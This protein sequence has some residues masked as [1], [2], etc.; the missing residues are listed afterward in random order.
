MTSPDP[1]HPVDLIIP[2][3]NEEQ[4]I[5]PLAEALPWHLFQNVYLI[6][7]AST[8]QTAK[9]AAE[10]GFT[11]I[12]ETNRGYGS[13][14][15]AGIRAIQQ[16]ETQ[17]YAIAFLDADLSD[18]PALLPDIIAPILR[19]TSDF[20]IASRT[21]LAEPGSLTLTQ[22]FGNRFACLLLRLTTRQKYNDLGPMRA[23]LYQALLEL[24]MR[25][26]T[27]GWTVEMQ[28]KAA[29]Q[30][31]HITEIDVPYRDR[32]AGQSKI[33]GSITGSIKAGYKILTTI[34]L[35]YLKRT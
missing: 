15:L 3:F 1:K 23:I 10:A 32:H 6:N 33:S 22:K 19:G 24:D 5:K 7:N 13:A 11:V 25:D 35:L 28:Y 14:C 2:A 20:V 26:S 9:L 12:S 27:W 29:T 16:S 31:L 8:D 17:P 21:K 4:N 34:G 30:K 18:N